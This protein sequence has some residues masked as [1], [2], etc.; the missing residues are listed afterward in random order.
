MILKPKNARQLSPKSLSSFFYDTLY[1]AISW[2]K[3]MLRVSGERTSIFWIIISMFR[4]I[5]NTRDSEFYW[6]RVFAF[7]SPSGEPQ[8]PNLKVSFFLCH[9]VMHPPKD[10]S[11]TSKTQNLRKKNGL[12]DKSVD[13]LIKGK[14]WLKNLGA[15]SWCSYY[16]RLHVQTFKNGENQWCHWNNGFWIVSNLLRCDRYLAIIKIVLL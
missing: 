1:C 10:F 15:K 12:H 11:A 13:A 14:N 6:N 16:S 2:M 8:F 4:G 3:V 7:K 9:S 5:L